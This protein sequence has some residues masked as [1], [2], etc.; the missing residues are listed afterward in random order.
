VLC[1]KNRGDRLIL[2]LISVLRTLV[3]ELSKRKVL[4]AEEFATIIGGCELRGTH[5]PEIGLQ[6]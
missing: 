6:S 2:A 1:E 3:L 4:D 5:A